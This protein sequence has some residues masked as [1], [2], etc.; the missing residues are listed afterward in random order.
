[1]SDNIFADVYEEPFTTLEEWFPLLADN[2]NSPP[3]TDIPSLAAYRRI[4]V[5][6]MFFIIKKTT[7]P[8]GCSAPDIPIG[9]DHHFEA[10]PAVTLIGR[11]RDW[12]L[13][14]PA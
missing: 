5:A 11:M 14:D 12:F 8:V 2:L 6:T 3:G 1:M 13:S 7:K 10:E 9:L 4:R